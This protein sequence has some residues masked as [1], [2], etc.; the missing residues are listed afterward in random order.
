MFSNFALVVW[1][2]GIRPG[3]NLEDEEVKRKLAKC[4]LRVYTELIRLDIPGSS[5]V[6]IS[7]AL[8]SRPSLPSVMKTSRERPLVVKPTRDD[9]QAPSRVVGKE[10]E[11][12]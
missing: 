8:A 2:L 6:S 4:H 5:S 11:E 12:R 9:L 1:S 10:E 3:L 7:R